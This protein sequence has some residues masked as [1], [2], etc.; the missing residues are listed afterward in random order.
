MYDIRGLKSLNSVYD[1]ILGALFPLASQQM[2]LLWKC[3]GK[4]G[5]LFITFWVSV[6]VKKWSIYGKS[7]EL[8]WLRILLDRKLFHFEF[9]V[10]LT[11]IYGISFWHRKIS[12]SSVEVVLPRAMLQSNIKSY[13]FEK[14]INTDFLN[15][16]VAES[17]FS[18]YDWS[19]AP[20]IWWIAV[21]IC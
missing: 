20:V 17:L 16:N 2:K 1:A 4:I 15:R 21:L 3:C 9:P 14:V 6:A 19:K 13:L 7:H 18:I 11:Q 8:L 10:I 12:L 5:S